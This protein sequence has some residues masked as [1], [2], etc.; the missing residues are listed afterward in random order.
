MKS[1]MEEGP[2]ARENFERAMKAVFRVPKAEVVKAEKEHK[3]RQK[4]KKSQLKWAER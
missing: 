2:K 3:A 1:E 4:R